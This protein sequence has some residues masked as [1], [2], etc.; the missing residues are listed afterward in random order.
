MNTPKAWVLGLFLIAAVAAGCST[1]EPLDLAEFPPD[2]V[3]DCTVDANWGVNGTPDINAEGFPT[4][5]EA[6]ADSLA[7]FIEEHDELRGPQ[8]I[9]EATASLL[10]EQNREVVIAIAGEV[11][12]DNWFV[13]TLSGC[14]G[15]ERF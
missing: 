10:N 3:L 15:F 14:P 5:I 9:R 1:A 11:S 8:P 2:A 13:T 4:A 7:P 12:P 6:L